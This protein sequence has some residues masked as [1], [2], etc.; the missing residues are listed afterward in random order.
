[1]ST[2]PDS[3]VVQVIAQ[4]RD[5]LKTVPKVNDKIVQV[6]SEEELGDAMKGVEFPCIGIV[7]EGMRAVPEMKE[8]NRQGVSA[9][10]V[11]SLIIVEKPTTAG[12]SRVKNR[13]INLLDLTRKAMHEGKS[14]AGHKW[15]FVLEAPASEKK[16]TVIWLQRWATP[17]QLVP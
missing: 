7:Y 10:L 11:L 14:P 2:P 13:T 17:I 1:M 15:R 5:I 4:V 3:L 9:E 8:T 16:G 12:E 6:Y